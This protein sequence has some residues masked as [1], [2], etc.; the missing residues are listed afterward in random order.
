MNELFDKAVNSSPLEFTFLQKKLLEQN[1]LADLLNCIEVRIKQQSYELTST[2]QAIYE[3]RLDQSKSNTIFINLSEMISNSKDSQ[4]L[5]NQLI[6]FMIEVIDG[7]IYQEAPIKRSRT[8]RSLRRNEFNEYQKTLFTQLLQH[9]NP[10]IND[11]Q[12]KR[13]LVSSIPF[14][15]LLE[16]GSL[17]NVSEY[18]LNTNFKLYSY[19][20]LKITNPQYYQVIIKKLA[21]QNL[22]N[23]LL[24]TTNNSSRKLFFAFDNKKNHEIQNYSLFIDILKYTDNLMNL[25][26]NFEILE[27]NVFLNKLYNTLENNNHAESLILKYSFLNLLSLFD[28]KTMLPEIAGW[29]NQDRLDTSTSNTCKALMPLFDKEKGEKGL[30]LS[31]LINDYDLIYRNYHENGVKNIVTLMGNIANEYNNW[32]GISTLFQIDSSIINLFIENVLN[33]NPLLIEKLLINSSMSCDI[34][35]RMFDYINNNFDNEISKNLLV[36]SIR[37]L[38]SNKFYSKNLEFISFYITSLENQEL[39]EILFDSIVKNIFQNNM[40]NPLIGNLYKYSEQNQKEIILELIMNEI[41]INYMNFDALE[42][43]LNYIAESNH[44]GEIFNKGIE[45]ISIFTAAKRLNTPEITEK[46]INTYANW[47]LA[48]NPYISILKKD[49]FEN[50]CVEDNAIIQNFAQKLFENHSRVV[51]GDTIESDIKTK[52]LAKICSNFFNNEY[53]DLLTM[54]NS[55]KTAAPKMDYCWDE[56]LAFKVSKFT[57]KG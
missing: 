16:N 32:G 43:V 20:L 21:P 6:D 15:F 8:L 37:C 29:I 39:K 3:L 14:S 57:P 11:L 13:L 12:F 56:N 40:I 17:N 25:L 24:L 49:I 54:K 31:M 51:S 45:D 38:E 42:T 53:T 47:L 4:F 33:E 36:I 26:P 9:F 23:L 19:E 28:I 30:K 41:R 10:S 22:I 7:N 18:A 44:I 55:M 1:R 46:L 52:I 27:K 35:A 5:K 34:I 50:P 2:I 48:N